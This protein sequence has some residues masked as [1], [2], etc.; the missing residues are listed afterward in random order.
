MLYLYPRFAPR[1]ISSRGTLNESELASDRAVNSITE[2]GSRATY[3]NKKEMEIELCEVNNE[4]RLVIVRVSVEGYS[5][6]AC[7]ESRCKR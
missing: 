5:E 6:L 3:F 7:A 4:D 1:K 2:D